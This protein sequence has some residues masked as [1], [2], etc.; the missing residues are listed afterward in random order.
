MEMTILKYF[1]LFI[2]CFVFLSCVEDDLPETQDPN[3]FMGVWKLERSMVN[4][5]AETLSECDKESTLILFWFSEAD[6]FYNAEIYTY[7]AN[8]S[9]EC[10]ETQRILNASWVPSLTFTSDGNATA[11]VP[12]TYTLE[13]DMIIRLEL[14]LEDELLTLQGEIPVENEMVSI[15][16]SYRKLRQQ[17]P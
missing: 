10:V 13:D 3:L 9:G 6:P 2:P 12:L 1:Y 8:E 14:G 7:Q 17:V 16:R 11:G 4:D 15:S 5:T